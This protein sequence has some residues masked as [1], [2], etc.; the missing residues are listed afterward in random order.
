MDASKPRCA[1]CISTDCI[2]TDDSLTVIDSSCEKCES[3]FCKECTLQLQEVKTFEFITES[4]KFGICVA[5]TTSPK[6]GDDQPCDSCSVVLS[7]WE[8]LRC[9]GCNKSICDQCH[10]KNPSLFETDIE[11]DHYTRCSLC[12]NTTVV[13]KSNKFINVSDTSVNQHL[14]TPAP[15][16]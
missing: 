2:E 1:L 6:D 5:C 12:Y 14:H 7:N 13:V 9:D 8:L 4:R 3:S 10:D 11:T 16:P 15:L